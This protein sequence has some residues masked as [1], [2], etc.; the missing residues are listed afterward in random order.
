MNALLRHERAIVTPI[1]GTTRDVITETINLNGIPATLLDTAGIGETKDVIEQ[2]GIDRSRRAIDAA[3]LALFVIDGS[4]PAAPDDL[5]VARLLA[6]RLDHDGAGRVVLAI[7][8]RDLPHHES[9]DVLC[10]ELPG[11]PVVELS[12]VSGS[13]ISTLETTLFE[14]ASSLA[15][16]AREPATVSLRQREALRSALNSLY[17]ALAAAHDALPND[18]I[19]IDVRDA[20]M[21]IGEITGEQISERVL[22]EIFSTF[23]IGK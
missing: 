2:M 23:C 7:N 4:Q 5:T 22:D 14:L 19:A 17:A 20:L 9:H 12:T 8:M 15:G 6:D 11:C 10:A 13:G 3:A 16:E 21:F 18:L 1:A